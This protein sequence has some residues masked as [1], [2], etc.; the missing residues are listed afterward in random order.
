[1]SSAR[2]KPSA[3]VV[4]ASRRF[5]IA[6]RLENAAGHAR[7]R[8]LLEERGHVLTYDWTAHGSVQDQGEARLRQVAQAETSGVVTADAVIV[9]LPGGCG[10]HAELGIAIGRDVPV[11][12]HTDGQDERLWEADRWCA[13]YAHPRVVRVRTDQ[14]LLAELQLM[15]WATKR[16][17]KAAPPV[18]P[19]FTLEN[20]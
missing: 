7:V 19:A 6:T 16:A 13:F 9:L 10:T 17:P 14:E 5:Y 18:K 11:V 3:A 12:L 20:W 8:A 2:R 4:D 1:V 15:G